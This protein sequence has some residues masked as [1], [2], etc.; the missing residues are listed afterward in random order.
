MTEED[1]DTASL[2]LDAALF[3]SVVVAAT[4]LGCALASLA[5]SELLSRWTEHHQR[6]PRHAG[7]VFLVGSCGGTTLGFGTGVVVWRQ[8][9]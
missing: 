2:V 6:V 8:W 4:T 1:S 3:V 9:K 7:L 5:T